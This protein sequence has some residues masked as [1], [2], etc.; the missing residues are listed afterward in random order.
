MGLDQ[1]HEQHNKEVKENGGVLGLTKGEK[2]MQHWM[3]CGPVLVR[4]VTEFE[5]SSKEGRN[6]ELSSP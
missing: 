3:G 5:L 6:N 4:A 2:K 1:R